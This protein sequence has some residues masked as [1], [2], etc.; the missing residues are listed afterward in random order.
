MKQGEYDEAV[1]DSA[2]N[3]LYEKLR[4]SGRNSKPVGLH[5]IRVASILWN[6]SQSESIIIAALL[7]DLVEDTNTNLSEIHSLFGADIAGIVDACTFD[8]GGDD[9]GKKLNAAYESIDR[10]REYGTSALLV[11]AADFIDNSNYYSLAKGIELR[12][13][14]CDKF[15]YFMTV[16]EVDLKNSPILEMLVKARSENVEKLYLS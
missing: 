6:L 4:E 1:I 15:M 3:F 7:H 12:K 14:L 2:V 9:Y 11:K 13:Y 16:A 5:S 10:A 8:Y